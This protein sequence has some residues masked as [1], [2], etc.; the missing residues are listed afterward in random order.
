[1]PQRVEPRDGTL[2]AAR[3]S[4]HG[5]FERETHAHVNFLPSVR[6]DT[7]S[8][9]VHVE[10]SLRAGLAPQAY[11]LE[12]A[13]DSARV[14]A[15]GAAGARHALATLAQLARLTDG[16]L[17]CAAIDDAPAF[18]VRGFMLDVSRTRVPTL[19]ALRDLVNELALL[20]YNQLQLYVEHT[21]AY[22][23]HD[24][25][26]RGASPLTTEDIDALDPFCAERGIELVPNQQSFGHFHRWLKHE[27]YRA[28]AEVPEGVVHA[29]SIDVE[30]YAL[31]PGDP[32][33]LALLEDL[34]DQLLPHFSSRHF[35]VGLDETFDLGLGRSKA[36][37]EQRGKHRVYVDFLRAVEERVRARGRRMM[38]WGDI[39]VEARELVPELPKDAIA[40]EW[41][42]ERGHPFDEHARLFAASG[43]EFHVCP[44]TSS[45][46]SVGGRI[47]N[48]L[49]NVREAALAGKR[50]G[51]RGYLLTDW[52][53]RGHLQPWPVSWP[54]ILAAAG[55]A[56]NVAS[57][58]RDIA[59]E[60]LVDDHAFRDPTR[61][62]DA[63][64]DARLGHV[65]A[66]LGRTG[67]VSGAHSTNGTALFFL[68]A[69]APQGLPH[70]RIQDLTP[71]GLARAEAHV[72]ALRRELDALAPTAVATECARRELVWACDLLAC[73]ARFGT[74]RLSAADGSSFALVDPALQT[75]LRAELAEL[76]ARH[77][78]LW[79][80]AH[81]PGGLDESCGWLERARA[82]LAAP[83][84]A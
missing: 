50:H 31:C 80:R 46:Q 1:M 11:R 35:N 38:F 61:S 55:C 27:P 41:G 83:A 77:R 19:S 28:L 65:L 69:F 9:A 63:A 39:V 36:E 78:A 75:S 52:G 4:V 62:R 56:W 70:A 68:L 6:G 48:M 2:R 16:V 17:P 14:F 5:D 47:E 22:R 3:W 8:S 13:P 44:G 57:A 73:A 40:L 53:D 15:S 58:E 25:V 23:G 24:V 42:Y 59:I 51:A 12:I 20:K 18:E 54:G 33:S 26:W 7:T 76:S 10:L 84:K 34:Y 67:E 49:A 21:F 72:L 60:R 79:T 29:F 37:C 66:E 43:L 81:R 30:P 82:V 32:R 71:A 64:P 74:A 45:W